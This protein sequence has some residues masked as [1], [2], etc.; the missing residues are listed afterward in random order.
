MM[1][2]DMRKLVS[3]LLDINNTHI[4]THTHR[5]TPKHTHT[6]THSPYT[7]P[8]KVME[9]SARLVATTTFL[10]PLGGVRKA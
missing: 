5:V 2:E 9:V 10:T 4:H 8:G 1:N 6:P 3:E 7:T